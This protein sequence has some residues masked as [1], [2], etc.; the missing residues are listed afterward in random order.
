MLI[1]YAELQVT[2][3]FSF[4]RGASHPEELVVT[5]A[6]LGLSAIGITDRNTLAGVV[7]AH[8]VAKQVG[9]RLVVGARLDLEASSLPRP[10]PMEQRDLATRP[11]PAEGETASTRTSPL[12]LRERE[13]AQREGEGVSGT[14][15]DI[16]FPL[17]RSRS[18][19]P[20]PSRERVS[21]AGLSLL[22][23]P[24]DRAAYGRLSRLL[25]VGRQ[26]A[27]KESAGSGLPTCSPTARDRLSSHCRRNS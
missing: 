6:A 7:R 17:S 25:S 26:R 8:V 5:A 16:A 22:C 24:T 2:T 12:P 9:I 15:S 18:L 10:S 1:R 20:S 21:G 3:N 11:L 4:L 27:P 23:F 14:D 13:L 19:A